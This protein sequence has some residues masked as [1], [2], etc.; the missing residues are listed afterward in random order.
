[1]S[2]TRARAS[3]LSRA[4][5]LL[6]PRAVQNRPLGPLTT[7]RVGGPAALFLEIRDESD[8][9]AVHRARTETG[10]PVLVIGKGSNLLVADAG[11]PGMAFM[12]GPPWT[13][14]TGSDG[15]ACAGGAAGL[16]RLA[17]QTAAAGQSGLEWAVGVP[18]SVGGGIRMNA[19]GHGSDV[20]ASLLTATIFD[21]ERGEC[22]RWQ[23]SELVLGYRHSALADHQ[24]VL[25]AR[26]SVRSGDPAASKAQIDEIVRWRR[27]HQPGGANAGSVF[28]NPDGD[29][30]GRLV[31]AAGFK[32][33]RFATAQVSPKHANFIQADAGGSAD[34][35]A[36]LIGELQ[37]RIAE[38]AGVQLRP[39]VRLV[40]FPSLSTSRGG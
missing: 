37:R 2:G 36:S 23:T 20:R 22:R 18:G 35:V 29:S 6:G 40:G 11:F 4:A 26:F 14:V 15:R 1:M 28:V 33:L 12:L 27:Q 32:G 5:V 25:S 17:R 16:P 21:L 7:Y 30:A 19:G 10:L 31:E 9:L 39:E 38:V 8:L 3:A 24:V 13:G 34:D